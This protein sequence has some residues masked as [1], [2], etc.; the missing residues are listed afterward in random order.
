MIHISN[1]LENNQ[2]II[3]RDNTRVG[4]ARDGR[5]R[6][7]SDRRPGF[8]RERCGA[9]FRYVTADGKRANRVELKRIRELTIP[10]A[11]DQVWICPYQNGHLQVTGRDAKGRKQYLYHPQW[12]AIRKETKFHRLTK[13]GRALPKIRKRVARDLR[14]RGLP[15]EKVIAAV[16]WLLEQ[17]HVRVGNPEYADENQSFGLST[18]RN[19]HVQVRGQRMEFRFRGKSGKFHKVDIT[20][21]RLARIVKRCQELPGYDLFQ[22]ID[23]AGET[24]NMTSEDV[25]NY[26][27][28]IVGEEFSAKDF[29]TWAGTIRAAQILQRLGGNDNEEYTASALVTAIDEVAVALGNTRA[30]CRKYYIHPAIMDAY[31]DGTLTQSFI[32]QKPGATQTGL[33]SEEAG[34]L[35]LLKRRCAAGRGT[36]RRG[37]LTHFINSPAPAAA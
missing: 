23:D 33:S 37:V 9:G 3:T 4:F 34:V 8:Q 11:W 26:L 21:Q 35:R 24:R 36:S 10:P 1:G 32:E 2:Q 31:L 18:M 29:R 22:Y 25:N 7:V 17:T 5:L 30:V 14:L 13:F 15:R 16:V 12:H 19:R 6:Y 20:N 27:H 28:G